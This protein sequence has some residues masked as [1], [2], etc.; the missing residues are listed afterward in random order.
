ML[1]A[2]GHSMSGIAWLKENVGG[3][4][5]IS[6]RRQECVFLLQVHL[7]PHH[8]IMFITLTNL[9]IMIV[10]CL[11]QLFAEIIML[12]RGA[13]I[14]HLMKME[15]PDSFT[16]VRTVT[17][18]GADQHTASRGVGRGRMDTHTKMVMV[19][20]MVETMQSNVHGRT[21]TAVE[22]MVTGSSQDELN[23]TA[24]V[25]S[26]KTCTRHACI[27]RGWRANSSG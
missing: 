7:I 26:Q 22:A 1:Y 8:Q 4:T 2:V 13:A 6:F 21:N 12:S 16:C 15:T 5:I 25:N 19:I 11:R 9:G 17:P 20:R 14:R 24:K 23:I 10:V 27:A 3:M 18:S